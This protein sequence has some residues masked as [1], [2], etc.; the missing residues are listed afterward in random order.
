MKINTLTIKGIRG[1]KDLLN[2]ELNNRSILIYGDNGSGK[3]SIT[4]AIEWFFYDLVEHLSGEEMKI[5][6]KLLFCI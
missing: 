2:M 1:I 6:R 5:K 4:D 3:S